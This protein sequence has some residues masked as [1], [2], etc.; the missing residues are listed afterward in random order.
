MSGAHYDK[1]M[2]KREIVQPQSNLG[3]NQAIRVC[4][5]NSLCYV[6]V[7]VGVAEVNGGRVKAGTGSVNPGRLDGAPA[8]SEMLAGGQGY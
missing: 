8:T 4:R 3:M 2:S 6:L 5:Y 7:A 1:G